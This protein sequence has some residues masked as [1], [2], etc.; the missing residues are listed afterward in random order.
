MS[1][2]PNGTS[3]AWGRIT[4]GSWLGS[5]NLRD[6]EQGSGLRDWWEGTARSRGRRDR[7]HRRDL[8]SARYWQRRRLSD[9]RRT[10]EGGRVRDGRDVHRAL[11]RIRGRGRRHHAGV[12]HGNC[13]VADKRRNVVLCTHRVDAIFALAYA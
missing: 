4:G 6:L 1:G 9:E 10:S 8:L 12:V 7:W 13:Q 5:L 3:E 2:E 11:L